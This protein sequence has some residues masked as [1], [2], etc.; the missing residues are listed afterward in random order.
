[1]HDLKRFAED[2]RER[3]QRKGVAEVV[4]ASGY[5][6]GVAELPLPFIHLKEDEGH[7]RQWKVML[8]VALLQVA[9]KN[10][11]EKKV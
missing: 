4:C 1:M 9:L 11:K 10:Q 7:I 5:V 2:Q 3:R 6:V 8:S